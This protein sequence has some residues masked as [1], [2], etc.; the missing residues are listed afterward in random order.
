[1]DSDT[2]DAVEE[3]ITETNKDTDANQRAEEEAAKD[4]GIEPE[5]GHA[6]D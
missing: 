2:R 1:M 6:Y 5:E 3:G 4:L